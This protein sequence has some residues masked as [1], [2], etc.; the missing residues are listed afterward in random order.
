MASAWNICTL[1]IKIQTVHVLLCMNTTGGKAGWYEGG[2]CN[3]EEDGSRLGYA[4]HQF[5]LIHSANCSGRGVMT[6]HWPDC[7]LSYAHLS[8]HR[9]SPAHG[10]GVCGA[11][12]SSICNVAIIKWMLNSAVQIIRWQPGLQRFGD[13]HTEKGRLLWKCRLEN[14]R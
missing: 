7:S 5:R 13:S 1:H 9:P 10:V 11:H 8:H 12:P 3:W 2:N 14:C 4:P 6:Q